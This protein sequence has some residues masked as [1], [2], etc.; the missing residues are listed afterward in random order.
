MGRAG[1]HK[2]RGG[3][4][5]LLFIFTRSHTPKPTRLQPTIHL[6]ADVSRLQRYSRERAG[7]AFIPFS[8]L[9]PNAHKRHRPVCE[10]APQQS[11]AQQRYKEN[12]TIKMFSVTLGNA[13]VIAHYNYIRS[14]E[15]SE[16]HGGHPQH[17][18]KL[19]K[20]YKQ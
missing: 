15:L 5:T 14:C 10:V 4:V 20:K 18:L 11:S 13:L 2:R 6:G 7:T 9:R 1:K 17:P 8:L 16:G 19:T 12:W 3:L